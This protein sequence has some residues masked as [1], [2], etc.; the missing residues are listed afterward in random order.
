[1]VE[2]FHE[3]FKNAV[4]DK[5][6]F[7]NSERVKAYQAVED[8][9][10]GENKIQYLFNLGTELVYSGD[11]KEARNKLGQLMEFL[12]Y[13]ESEITLENKPIQNLIALTYLF[14][15]IEKEGEESFW[16]AFQFNADFTFTNASKSD[17]EK[18]LE[19]F[20]KLNQN[21]PEDIYLEWMIEV[22]RNL[23][24][25][26]SSL[27][28]DY[29][30][31]SIQIGLQ[32]KNESKQ[33][34]WKGIGLIGG[35]CAEDFSGD[36]NLDVIYGSIGF[37]SPL[38]YLEGNKDGG[39][40]YKSKEAQLEGLIGGISIVKGDFDNDGFPDVFVSRGGTLSASGNQPNSLLKNNGDGTFSDVTHS[41]GVL[42]F[43]P[44]NHAH[45][46]DFNNDGHLDI[47]IANESL[48]KY[49]RNAH[50]SR[51]YENKGD[52]TFEEVSVKYGLPISELVMGSA[53]L[54]V[55]NDG[56]LDLYLSIEGGNNRLFLNNGKEDGKLWSFEEVPDAAG[57]SDP[58]F[59]NKCVAVDVNQDGLEDLLVFPKIQQQGLGYYA[60]HLIKNTHELASPRLFINDGKGR[61][62]DQSLEWG[63][64]YNLMGQGVGVGDLDNNGYPD[65]YVGTGN[66]NIETMVPNVILENN[67]VKLE[68]NSNVASVGF[69]GNS[70]SIQLVDTYQ[71][72]KLDIM[73]TK[74][75][76]FEFEKHVPV[77]LKNHTE[78][79]HSWVQVR[80]QGKTANYQGIGAKIEIVAQTVE[81]SIKKFHQRINTQSSPAIA[82]FGL[83]DAVAITEIIVH[84]PDKYHSVQS[85][86]DPKINTLHII[87]QEVK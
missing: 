52:G 69:L 16:D 39:F 11:Y 36:G 65:F 53:W 8:S 78:N 71:N 13:D 76:Y 2:I 30:E 44:S 64:D 40:S 75:G 33:K 35:L 42:D 50:P 80:L 45:F 34:G 49:F 72:G 20:R 82:H 70:Y 46:V 57:A 81:G 26:K 77:F 41:A 10:F 17:L 87:K 19:L 4:A 37:D 24:G 15:A 21:F 48:T 85:V 3:A 14:E 43:F 66:S 55:N 51:L 61:F 86:Q 83:G 22:I 73:A 6:Y 58:V 68:P 27:A 23:E 29:S 60:N 62:E 47:F 12:N 38:Y 1:M 59:S 79:N 74:G 84:W 63:I 9:V 67:G 31:D 28:S 56:L 7:L 18:S 54:D 32:F 25:K 5:Y